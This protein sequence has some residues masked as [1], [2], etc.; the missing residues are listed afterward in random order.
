MEVTARE[1]HDKEFHDAWRGYNQEEVDDF[2]D[3]IAEALDRLQREN[4]ALQRRMTEL[5]QTV[6]TSRTTEDMLKQ[7]LVSAQQAAEEAVGKAKAKAEQLLSEAGERARQVDQ[8]T[9]SKLAEA[10]AEIARRIGEDD[11]RHQLHKQELDQTIERLETYETDLKSRLQGFLEGQL[12]SLA[13]LQSHA[14][15]PSAPNGSPREM[16]TQ[17]PPVQRPQKR[18]PNTGP[19][20]SRQPSEP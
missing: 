12:K 11:R 5:D 2:L 15:H 19:L 1:I 20:P 6:S 18:Q 4:V 17:P 7:T 14:R 9:T 10:E 16:H 3:K 13:T 8:E